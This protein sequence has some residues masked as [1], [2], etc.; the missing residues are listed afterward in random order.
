MYTHQ[1]FPAII[2]TMMEGGTGAPTIKTITTCENDW[3]LLWIGSSKVDVGKRT[4][5]EGIHTDFIHILRNGDAVQSQTV[6]KSIAA[7]INQ[8]LRK[9]DGL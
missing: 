4:E 3:N 9:T 6:V 2:V 8:R 1:S 7:Y 5:P